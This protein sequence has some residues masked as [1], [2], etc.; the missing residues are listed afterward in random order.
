MKTRYHTIDIRALVK[1]LQGLIGL[2]VANI[3]DINHR[4]YLFKLAKPDHKAF[5]LIESGMLQS[6][7]HSQ[8]L[9]I[10][11]KHYFH[12]PYYIF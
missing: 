8:A 2:R 6:I 4:T 5:L 12:S 10:T 1:N 3:Y 9:I 11:F 7:P